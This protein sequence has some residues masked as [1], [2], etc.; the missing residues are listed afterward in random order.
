VSSEL[1]WVCPDCKTVWIA[2]FTQV[3]CRKCGCDE[4]HM[5]DQEL[6]ARKPKQNICLGDLMLGGFLMQPQ[7]AR[8]GT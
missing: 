7:P 8:K 6:V 3:V 4:V 1:E 5:N 2:D